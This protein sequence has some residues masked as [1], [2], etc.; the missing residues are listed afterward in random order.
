L[1]LDELSSLYSFK[2]L[3]DSSFQDTIIKVSC[4]GKSLLNQSKKIMD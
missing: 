1:E 2:D 3:R 4:L